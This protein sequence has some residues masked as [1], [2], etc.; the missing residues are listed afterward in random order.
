MVGED[1]DMSSK[2][3]RMIRIWLTIFFGLIALMLITNP[4]RAKYGDRFEHI[5]R[6]VFAATSAFLLLL[7]TGRI[8]SILLKRRTK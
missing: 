4:L 8:L 1:C 7:F 3:I 2:V 6:S 5:E